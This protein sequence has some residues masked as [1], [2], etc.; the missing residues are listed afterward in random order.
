MRLILIPNGRLISYPE[1]PARPSPLPRGEDA[2]LLTLYHTV[3]EI[4]QC[5]NAAGSSLTSR[6][7]AKA[8]LS[9]PLYMSL[10]K[11]IYPVYR[12]EASSSAE[13][14]SKAEQLLKVGKIRVEPVEQKSSLFRMLITGK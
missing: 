7:V 8:L 3:K 10:Y 9:S 2:A 5:A 4:L 14:K 13:A 1:M 12:I 6:A 11:V